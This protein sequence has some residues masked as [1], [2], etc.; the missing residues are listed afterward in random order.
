MNS[1]WEASLI[2]CE[3]SCQFIAV[4]GCDDQKIEENDALFVWLQYALFFC[5]T[6][7]LCL[8]ECAKCLEKLNDLEKLLKMQNYFCLWQI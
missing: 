1:R 4:F 2:G 6:F 7:L 5:A 8:P 3:K